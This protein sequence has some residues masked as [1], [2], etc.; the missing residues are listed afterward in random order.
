MS[1]SSF[2]F[3]DPEVGRYQL[4]S[5]SYKSLF[6]D[7]SGISNSEK[8][9]IFRIDTKTG[10]TWIFIDHSGTAYRNGWLA[11]TNQYFNEPTIDRNGIY[12]SNYGTFNDIFLKK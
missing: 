9:A 10:Q 12:S 8:E 2:V 4:C 7:K 1:I 3:A 6:G 5:G 11:I